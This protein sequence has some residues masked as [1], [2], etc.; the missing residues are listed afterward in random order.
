M[1]IQCLSSEYVGVIVK[2]KVIKGVIAHQG[3]IEADKKSE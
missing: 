1:Q 3:Q 2:Q